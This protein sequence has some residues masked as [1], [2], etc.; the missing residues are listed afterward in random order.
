MKWIESFKYALNK[1]DIQTIGLLINNLPE[2]NKIED[3]RSA[4]AVIGEAKKQ[5]EDTQLLIQ[6]K[7]NRFH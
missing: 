3:M 7:M 6:Q 4:Y 2:F 1:Q 5:F